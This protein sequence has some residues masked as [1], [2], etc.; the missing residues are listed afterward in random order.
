MSQVAKALLSPYPR[1]RARVILPGGR[2]LSPPQ[3]SALV[4]CVALSPS[5]RA[6]LA[7]VAD[8]RALVLHHHD[9]H[10]RGTLAPPV[11]TGGRGL[12]LFRITASSI[13]T[14]G[15]EWRISYQ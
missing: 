7:Q 14:R 4:L 2:P 12:K 6:G 1:A 13:D 10:V 11:K 3:R 8:E 9:V 5:Q 15:I